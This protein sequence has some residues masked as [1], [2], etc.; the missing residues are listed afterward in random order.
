MDKRIGK[1]S[2]PALRPNLRALEGRIVN[3]IIDPWI[4]V[5]DHEAT[6]KHI[7]LKEL[8]C[9]PGPFTISLRRDDLEL[10]TLQLAICLTQVM[11]APKDENESVMRIQ[12]PL[13]PDIYDQAAEPFLDMFVVDHPEQP[14][15]QF[16]NAQASE[17]TP[18][19]KYFPGLPEGNNACFFNTVGEMTKACPACTALVLFHQA[20]NCPN[21]SGKHKG[22]L[23]GGS[24]IT[25]FVYEDDLRQCIWKNVM[26]SVFIQKHFPQ[27]SSTED[28]PVWKNWWEYGHVYGSQQISLLRGLF[29]QAVKIDMIWKTLSGTCDVCGLP[30]ENFAVAFKAWASH[31]CAITGTWPHPF[32]ARRFEK[33]SWRFISYNTTEPA[34]VRIPSLIAEEQGQTRPLVLEHWR[35]ID[36]SSPIT[37]SM[38]G[39]RTKQAAI[40]ERRHDMTPLPAGWGENTD[41]LIALLN[42]ALTIR[43]V[44]RKKVYGLGKALG[45]P[46]LH[47]EAIRLFYDRSEE[48]IHA[49]LRELD[50]DSF[51]QAQQEISA[52]FIHLS[53]SILDEIIEPYTHKP[54]TFKKT[55]VTR[56]T[57]GK[58]FKKIKEGLQ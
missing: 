27:I 32:S 8:L 38:G 51:D 6:R 25:V 26:N 41:D 14:F 48:Y 35:T 36:S 55:A 47:L 29:W 52:K 33:D 31:M 40:L 57:L 5:V 12:S 17:T 11:L 10:A 34:W 39:Y 28:I 3:L 24:P 54:E 49:M 37:L 1:W 9:S 21:W 58:E 20:S 19:Q 13:L 44:F 15:M 22:G 16:R 18:I 56:A 43:D 23:R 7:S 4:P 53:L 42:I 46:S 50:W 30:S 45:A 2:D